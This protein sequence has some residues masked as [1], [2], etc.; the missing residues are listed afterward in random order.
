MRR[1]TTFCSAL[2]DE[3]MVCKWKKMPKESEWREAGTNGNFETLSSDEPAGAVGPETKILKRKRR[4]KSEP[5]KT[6]G[7]KR[8]REKKKRG[9][10]RMQRKQKRTR[11]ICKKETKWTIHFRWQR[12]NTNEIAKCKF[13]GNIVRIEAP[14][15]FIIVRHIVIICFCRLFVRTCLW[16]TL[17]FESSQ[18]KAVERAKDNEKEWQTK[19]K[20]CEQKKENEKVCGRQSTV[21]MKRWREAKNAPGT[22]W[23]W[24]EVKELRW[25]SEI[26]VEKLIAS[27]GSN[28]RE[29]GRGRAKQNERCFQEWTYEKDKKGLPDV[30]ISESDAKIVCSTMETEWNWWADKTKEGSGL[31]WV[32]P[33]VGKGRPTDSTRLAGTITGRDE[34]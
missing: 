24:N 11:R 15:W 14:R 21:K 18:V 12:A 20:K 34:R 25:P 32:A 33:K 1:T 23:N 3:N 27:L 31:A 2:N 26:E 29:K 5:K 8:R 19:K 9:P 6:N 7:R 4:K 17:W 28:R 30:L 22:V 13:D 10:G 16:S